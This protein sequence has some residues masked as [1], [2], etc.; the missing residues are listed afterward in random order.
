MVVPSEL[1]FILM[2]PHHRDFKPKWAICD[3]M[4]VFATIQI[5]LSRAV[6]VDLL[7]QAT[8]FREQDS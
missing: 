7:D 1:A 8:E 6:L 4:G 2:E 3:V 5:V